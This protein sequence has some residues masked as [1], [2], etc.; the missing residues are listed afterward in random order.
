MIPSFST[1]MYAPSL[2]AI[3]AYMHVPPVLVRITLSVFVLAF[4]LGQF[5]LG[6]LSDQ[7]G[8]RKVLLSSLLLYTVSSWLASQSHHI[9]SFIVCRLFQGVACAGPSSISKAVLN[10]VFS[11]IEHARAF[12]YLSLF[13]GLGLVTAPFLGGYLQHYLSW[14]WVFYVLSML[15]VSLFLIVYFFLPE[16]RYASTQSII[17][18]KLI[19]N[20]C[21]EV[22]QSIS[23]I[24][25]AT[26]NSIFYMIIL[27]FSIMGPFLIQN[28]WHY[29]EVF[30]GHMAFIIG[31]C[32]VVGSYFSG[33]LLNHFRGKRL[34][35]MGMIVLS[36]LA[37]ANLLLAIYVVNN[38]YSLMIPYALIVLVSA[39]A[40]PVV[41]SSSISLFDRSMG[42]TSSSMLGLITFVV[43]ALGSVFISHIH[44][45]SVKPWAWIVAL[46]LVINWLFTCLFMR[47]R[48]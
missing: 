18:Y 17:D 23:F 48:S 8:R 22:L 11:G 28:H 38:I 37:I 24:S 5:P 43:A 35:V 12:V 4:G 3:T 15:G 41:M 13:W 2:P 27:V 47:S 32:W 30:Y 45:T 36:L 20:N 33:Y 19:K 6:I 21:K 14:H 9:T 1:D 46:L 7:Y 44:P 25:C 40:F 31:V 29:S 16:T 34:L 10:D 39:I 42:G 26:M